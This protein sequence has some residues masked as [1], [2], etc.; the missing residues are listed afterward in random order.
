M[1]GKDVPEVLA[2]QSCEADVP[3]GSSPQSDS[4]LAIVAFPQV[5][6]LLRPEVDHG[7]HCHHER[8][9][10][11]GAQVAGDTGQDDLDLQGGSVGGSPQHGHLVD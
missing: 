7:A 1:Q 6:V 3:A 4:C 2:E 8:V 10:E 9:R 11:H 5:D